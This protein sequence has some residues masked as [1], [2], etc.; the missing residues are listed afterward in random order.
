M[1]DKIR[2]ESHSS[3]EFNPADKVGFS[4]ETVDDFNIKQSLSDLKTHAKAGRLRAIPASATADDLKSATYHLLGSEKTAEVLAAEEAGTP[5]YD[6]IPTFT[7]IFEQGD[8]N[9]RTGRKRASFAGLG[10]A[11]AGADLI[12]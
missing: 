10:D 4:T 6:V 12:S 2:S 1:F 5:V 3:I 8:G 9:G 11:D 7:R